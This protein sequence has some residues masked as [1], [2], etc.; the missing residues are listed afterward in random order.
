MKVDVFTYGSLMFAPVWQRVV[1]GHH[2]SI[3]ATL[4]GYNR[5]AVAGEAYPGIL[6]HS[7][8]AHDAQVTGLVYLGV[9]ADDLLRLDRFEGEDYQRCTVGVHTDAAPPVLSA[10]TYVYKN[11]ARL[12]ELAWNPQEFALEKFMASYCRDTAGN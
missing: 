6:A 1:R 9:D 10:Q 7:E 3:E 5:F 8:S 11:A 2:R 12:S 4:F